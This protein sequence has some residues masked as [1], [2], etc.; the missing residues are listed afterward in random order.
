MTPDYTLKNN[1]HIGWDNS[2]A[3]ALK[4]TPGQIVEFE[5]VDASGG[6][7]NAFPL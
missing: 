2:L 7:L 3:P 6:Q 1:V 5:A 4:V